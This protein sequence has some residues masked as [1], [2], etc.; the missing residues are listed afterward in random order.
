MVLAEVTSAVGA[1]ILT[2]GEGNSV[3]S[4]LE[5]HRRGIESAD[6]EERLERLEK[7]LEGRGQRLARDS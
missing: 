2:P 1:G 3:A 7:G 6:R 4:L 5:L